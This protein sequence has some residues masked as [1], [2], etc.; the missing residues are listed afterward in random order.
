MLTAFRGFMDD[1]EYVCL[2]DIHATDVGLSYE[3]GVLYRKGTVLSDLLP[4][5][6]AVLLELRK[7]KAVSGKELKPSNKKRG[8][9]PS[10]N[11]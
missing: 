10:E 2:F 3:L 8:A 11:K 9:G 7:I 1:E 5:A 4:A 6:R